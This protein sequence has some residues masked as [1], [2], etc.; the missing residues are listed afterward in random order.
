MIYH[1]KN[2]TKVNFE[3]IEL[4]NIYYGISSSGPRR[5]FE[6]FDLA[7]WIPIFLIFKKVFFKKIVQNS[8]INK[9]NIVS[10]FLIFACSCL[11]N[12]VPIDLKHMSI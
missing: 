2:V 4:Y 5:Y 3:S 8:L 6:F 10:N 1:C 11:Q 9:E 7:S 12:R